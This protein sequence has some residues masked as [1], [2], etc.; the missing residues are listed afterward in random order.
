[1]DVVPVTAD[2]RGRYVAF[3]RAVAWAGVNGG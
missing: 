2:L 1:V 3:C